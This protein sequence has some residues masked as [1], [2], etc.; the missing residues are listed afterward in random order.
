MIAPP[1]APVE[2]EEYIE[3]DQWDDE[4]EDAATPART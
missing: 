2:P 4:A 1:P 3:S